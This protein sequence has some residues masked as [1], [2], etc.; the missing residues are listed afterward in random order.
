MSTIRQ[1]LPAPTC[2]PLSTVRKQSYRLCSRPHHP[3]GFYVVCLAVLCERWAAYVLASSVVFML[4]D[5]YGYARA[6]AL[7]VAGLVNAASY[8]GTLPG[9]LAADRIFGARRALSIST[10]LFALGYAMLTVSGA[11]AFWLSVGLLVLG[12]SLFKPGTQTAIAGLYVPADP[13]LDAAQ[14][15]FYLA[16]NAG[17]A[18]GALLAGLVVR[19]SGWGLAYALAAA[20][21]LTGR[22]VL[23]VGRDT[24]RLRAAGLHT[25]HP[26]APTGRIIPAW[27][28]CKMMGA[29]TLAMLIYT[30]CFAQAEGSLLLWA[31]DRT[32][33][34]IFG[35]EIP[36]AWFAGLPPM[37]V[38][39]LAPI[40][41]A[42]LSRLQ[43]RV[44]TQRLIAWGLLAVALA[45][46]TFSPT[47]VGYATRRVSM[48]WLVGC[49]TLMVVGELLIGPLGLSLLL[50]LAP[51]RL[52]GVVVG[53]WYV[54][55]SF[56]FLLAGEIGALW[57][58]WSPNGVLTLLVMLPLCGAGL[59]W[60][61]API[62]PGSTGQGAAADKQGGWSR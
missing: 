44:G 25:A 32:D 1:S 55:N 12:S 17:A 20:V 14:V 60:M 48:G 21:M 42:L 13:R 46:I 41:L 36:A 47:V 27:Q 7:R 34:V 23:W 11:T 50:R 4:C 18:L 38:L 54:A 30:I 45:Y 8:L 59:L 49:L 33:R 56:G 43:R 3:P 52:V 28:R 10:V 16:V 6:E 15:M 24:L 29:L 61:T 58:R 40:Q 53:V 39:M 5:R 57:V 19:S 9:G 31:Q 35:F 62:I 2:N 51:R 26:D 37:L 22:L